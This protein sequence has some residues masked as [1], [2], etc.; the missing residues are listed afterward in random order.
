MHFAVRPYLPSDFCAIYRICHLTSPAAADPASNAE[1]HGHFY[2]GPYIHYEPDL[3]FVLTGD[4][5]PCGYVL[6][7]RDSTVFAARMEQEWLPPLRKRY[8]LRPPEDASHDAEN[9]KRMHAG[10][11]VNKGLVATYP[12]HLHIDL[13]PL[14]QD[15]KMGHKLMDAFL[16]RLTT[17]SV[18][19]VYL[20]T[21]TDNAR[22]VAFYERA[23]FQ[24]KVNNGSVL[25]T[26][27]LPRTSGQT[28][29]PGAS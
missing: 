8:P 6:G 2:A 5:E 18:A 21:N 27:R 3:C 26:M 1:L 23:G 17:L 16:D 15:K 29:N 14:A 20:G 12:A 11:S 28:P 10:R 22:A 25:F 9:I 19:G 13:L 24:S 7:A 4:E